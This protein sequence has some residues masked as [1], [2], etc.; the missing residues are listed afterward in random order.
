[1][2]AILKDK[3]VEKFPVTEV[4]DQMSLTESHQT[5]PVPRKKLFV[6]D[7]PGDGTPKRPQD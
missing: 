6:E 3:P 5:T 7:L 2:E 1:M 4:T